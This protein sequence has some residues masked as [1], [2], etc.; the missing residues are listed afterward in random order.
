MTPGSTVQ[1]AYCCD[2]SFE[3]VAVHTQGQMQML[4]PLPGQ[5]GLPDHLPVTWLANASVTA[6]AVGSVKLLR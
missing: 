4:N 1:Q 3:V 2:N 5:G 6:W